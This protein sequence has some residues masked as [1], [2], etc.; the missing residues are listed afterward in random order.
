[1]L[2]PAHL[3]EWG[4][5]LHHGLWFE[6]RSWRKGG[7]AGVRWAV[8]HPCTF[9]ALPFWPGVSLPAEPVMVG[10]DSRK[11]RGGDYLLGSLDLG[12]LLVL[13]GESPYF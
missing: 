10:R 9:M 8:P 7:W 3:P 1:M 13:L 11:R 6:P 5:A 2:G 12:L 4:G